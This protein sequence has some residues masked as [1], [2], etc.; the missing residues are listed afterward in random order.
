MATLLIVMPPKKY[1]NNDLGIGSLVRDIQT[2][3]L[4]LLIERADLF[5]NVEEHEPIWV[6]SMT[7][8][9]PATDSHNRHIPFIE[10]A[11][12]GLLNSGVWELKGNE[13]D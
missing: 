3:D 6:W 1:S 9:G 5:D 13:T 8:T 4:G 2:G 7:W 10:E 12:V 11:I